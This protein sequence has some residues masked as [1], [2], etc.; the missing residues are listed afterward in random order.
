MI[1]KWPKFNIGDTVHY[2]YRWGKFAKESSLSGTWSRTIYQIHKVRQAHKFNP[3]HIYELA[4]LG[5]TIPIKGLP[6]IQENLL[7]TAKTMTTDEEPTILYAVEKILKR[8]GKKVLVK[9]LGY[10]VPT[11]K[12]A[13]SIQQINKNTIVN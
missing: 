6:P 5:K 8:R 11:W 4:E 12:P 13:S 2:Y 1:K 3:M 10:D 7:K 9:W